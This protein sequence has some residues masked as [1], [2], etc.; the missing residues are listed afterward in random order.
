MVEDWMR[1]GG[2]SA[3]DS[4]SPKETSLLLV[5]MMSQVEKRF[6]EDRELNAQFLELVIQVYR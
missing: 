2:K 6:S 5:K 3:V 1:C 4:P